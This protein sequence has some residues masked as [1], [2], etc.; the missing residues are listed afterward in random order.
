MK[1]LSLA[2]CPL[3]LAITVGQ[4]V[5]QVFCDAGTSPADHCQLDRAQYYIDENGHCAGTRNP[6]HT[7]A[8]RADALAACH[9]SDPS[10]AAW[11]EAEFLAC[12]ARNVCFRHSIRLPE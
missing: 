5:G 8:A 3:I 9:Q 2:L 4:S 1:T 7:F 6:E 11:I 10:S 12:V